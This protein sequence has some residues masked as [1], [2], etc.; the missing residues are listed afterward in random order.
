MQLFI[1][2]YAPSSDYYLSLMILI[3]TGVHYVNL[4][5]HTLPCQTG[6]LCFVLKDWNPEHEV[7]SCNNIYKAWHRCVT[8]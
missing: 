7:R 6:L 1:M 4:P 2:Q 5:Q 8:S 3:V